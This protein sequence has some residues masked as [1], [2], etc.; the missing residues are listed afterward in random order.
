MS[1]VGQVMGAQAVADRNLKQM[2][3]RPNPDL[4][5]LTL[6]HLQLDMHGSK[7]GIRI[8]KLGDVLTLAVS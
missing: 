5:I 6:R 1:D 2:C 7:V 4:S 8:S 3:V